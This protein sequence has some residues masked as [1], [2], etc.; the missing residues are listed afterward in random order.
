MEQD[1][2]HENQF[3]RFHYGQLK[4]GYNVRVYGGAVLRVLK[5][6]KSFQAQSILKELDKGNEWKQELIAFQTRS[7]QE[8][9][10]RNSKKN[11]SPWEGMNI[12]AKRRWGVLNIIQQI[13]KR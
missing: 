4:V 8:Q 2:S 5:H 12:L 6:Y 13:L 1:F 10:Q 7:R 3:F 11:R 9:K